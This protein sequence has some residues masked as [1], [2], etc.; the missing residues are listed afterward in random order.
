MRDG[1]GDD[2]DKDEHERIAT[3]VIWWRQCF[4]RYYVD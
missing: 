3:L 1:C 4:P 2:D